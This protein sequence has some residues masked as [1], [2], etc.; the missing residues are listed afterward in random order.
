MGLEDKNAF[1]TPGD[2]DDTP[3]FFSTLKEC[4]HYDLGEAYVATLSMQRLAME[5]SSNGALFHAVP[6]PQRRNQSGTAFFHPGIS[7]LIPCK[8]MLSKSPDCLCDDNNAAFALLLGLF[9]GRLDTSRVN[10]SLDWLGDRY[11]YVMRSG[12]T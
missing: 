5:R 6:R 9:Y 2:T 1:L 4:Y 11:T 10:R 3:R 8:I 12:Q 7:S